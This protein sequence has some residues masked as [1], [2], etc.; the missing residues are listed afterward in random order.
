LVALAGVADVPTPA[1][2]PPLAL[3]PAPRPPPPN[4]RMIIWNGL[5]GPEDPSSDPLEPPAVPSAILWW[6]GIE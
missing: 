3:L 6:S 2:E 1:L 4:N 5:L